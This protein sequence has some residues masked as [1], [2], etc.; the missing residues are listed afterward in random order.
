[1][2]Y[3]HEQSVSDQVGFEMYFFLFCSGVFLF[4]FFCLFIFFDRRVSDLGV[5]V[6][7]SKIKHSM[8]IGLYTEFVF[9]VLRQKVMKTSW[10]DREQERVSLFDCVA[11][12][13]FPVK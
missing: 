3:L 13:F 7:M 1:M 8:A 5:Q 12:L 9:K 6:G 10:S 4:F 11:K 2:E